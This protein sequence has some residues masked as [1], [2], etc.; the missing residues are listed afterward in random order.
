MDATASECEQIKRGKRKRER[1]SPS[2]EINYIET[3]SVSAVAIEQLVAPIEPFASAHMQ[4]H[5]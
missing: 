1:K 2:I 3:N 5:G 4:L